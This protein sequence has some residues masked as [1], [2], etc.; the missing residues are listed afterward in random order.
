MSPRPQTTRSLLDYLPAIYQGSTTTRRFLS[1]FDAI[2]FGISEAHDSKLADRSLQDLIDGIAGLFDPDETRDDFL[3][4]LAQ[5][6]AIT[7]LASIP[8]ERR[9]NVIRNI[10]P[11]YAFRGTK[12][13]VEKVIELYTGVVATV[14][15]ND[16]P[17]LR[18]GET[19]TIGSNTRLGKDTF[20]FRVMLDLAALPDA[21]RQL[22][23]LLALHHAIV[24]ASKPAHTHFRLEHNVTG[25]PRGFVIGRRSTLGVDTLLWH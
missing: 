7:D 23:E 8:E 24:T 6:V 10:I 22:A 17:G 13:Y 2:L 5:W 20:Y 1:A 25:K 12:A 16:L 19:A 4:W 9:R 14:E 3:P 18:V 11:L 21:E 15:E